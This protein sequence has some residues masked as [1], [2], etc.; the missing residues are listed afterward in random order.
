MAVAASFFA[1][2]L[3]YL[4]AVTATDA[5]SDDLAPVVAWSNR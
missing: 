5:V 3:L 1:T 4:A 2:F